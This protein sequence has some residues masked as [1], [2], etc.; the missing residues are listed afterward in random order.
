LFPEGCVSAAIVGGSF[1][2]L[3]L[4]LSAFDDSLSKK[5]TYLREKYD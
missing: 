3:F 5:H 4:S 2:E 1:K